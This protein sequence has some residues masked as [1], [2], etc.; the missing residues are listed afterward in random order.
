M[1]DFIRPQFSQTVVCE[2][3]LDRKA[4]EQ[5]IQDKGVSFNE[6]VDALGRAY[7][8]KY[9]ARCT[10]WVDGVSTPLEAV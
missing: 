3:L 5:Y 7:I 4:V 9:G 6:A 2:A 1:T 8:E 10:T